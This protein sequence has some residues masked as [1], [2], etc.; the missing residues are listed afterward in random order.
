M[1]YLRN[2]LG[3]GTILASVTARRHSLCV[4]ALG[5]LLP[6]ILTLG[7]IAAAAFTKRSAPMDRLRPLVRDLRGKDEPASQW[8]R[9]TGERAR[10][11]AARNQPDIT[12]NAGDG[13][14]MAMRAAPKGS[15]RE[16]LESRAAS[17]DRPIAGGGHGRG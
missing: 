7:I 3:T 10:P 6:A 1:R 5:A 17:K 15:N 11:L 4:L 9:A 2:I 14:S 8:L 12:C 16:A 13:H